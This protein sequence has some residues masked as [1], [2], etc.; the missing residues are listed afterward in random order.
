ML[1]GVAVY[2]ESGGIIKSVAGKKLWRGA[3]QKV[4]VFDSKFRGLW[5]FFIKDFGYKNTNLEKKFLAALVVSAKC[6]RS[7]AVTAV[8]VD[9]RVNGGRGSR[10]GCER[11]LHRIVVCA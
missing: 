3:T 10:V 2:R 11:R 5:R 6:T 1:P 8:R 9:A 4:A 7:S